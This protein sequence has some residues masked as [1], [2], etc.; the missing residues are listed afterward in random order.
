MSCRLTLGREREIAMRKTLNLIAIGAMLLIPLQADAGSGKKAL[1]LGVVVAGGSVAMI[2][3]TIPQKDDPDDCTRCT[4]DRFT[5]A[6]GIVAG[7]GAGMFVGG[8]Y[9]L[10]APE[11]RER[12]SSTAATNSALL[13]M[14][15][16]GRQWRLPPLSYQGSKWHVPLLSVELDFRP[17]R[18]SHANRG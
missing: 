12:T 11:S 17:W 1:A 7:V 14:G 4:E 18:E 10:L 8:I 3:A 9:Y 16:D 5:T 15:K 6:G 13:T 2:E